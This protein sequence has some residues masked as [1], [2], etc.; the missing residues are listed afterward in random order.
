MHRRKNAGKN[1]G[2]KFQTYQIENVEADAEIIVEMDNEDHPYMKQKIV[3]KSMVSL[4]LQNGI[5]GKA[6]FLLMR[7]FM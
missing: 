5:P 2:E 3:L 6:V 7:S 1:D 4:L